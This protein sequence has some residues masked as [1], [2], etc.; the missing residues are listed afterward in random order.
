M[1]LVNLK[2]ILE[3]AN[4]SSYAVGAFDVFN[5][6]MAAGV[7][8][9]AEETRSPVILAYVD[10]FD[11]LFPME[12]FI[13]ALHIYA[14]KASVPVCIHLDH[15]TRFSVIERAVRCGFTSVMIDASDKE[16]SEN[17]AI[18][19][20]VV[21]LCRPLNISV[22]AE[23]GHVAGNEGM[24]TH[25]EGVYT[26]PEQALEFVEK[27]GIDALAVSVGTVHGVYKSTPILSF[28]RCEAIKKAVNGLPLVLHGGSGLSDE[29]FRH[30]IACGINKV[31]IFTD[32]T[33]EAMES[34]RNNDLSGKKA[35]FSVSSDVVRT[36]KFASIKK[37]ERFGCIG[38]A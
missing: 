1:T 9:A 37:L 34:L 27:T 22:E 26:E 6:E 3:N 16:F 23:L 2:E 12:A 32:L 5:C 38:K 25:D 36:I 30:I 10:M 20:Q 19:S 29:D 8:Q 14:E 28:E 7:L 35:Y 4:Q 18:T 21:S 13:A 31:N 11:N 15:A 17:I 24:Y 33:L